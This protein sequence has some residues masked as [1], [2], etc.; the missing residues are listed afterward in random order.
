M[1][2]LKAPLSMCI[3][4]NVPTVYIQFTVADIK[5][6]MMVTGTDYL[7][8]KTFLHGFLHGYFYILKLN[9]LLAPF[10]GHHFVEMLPQAGISNEP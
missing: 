10:T 4:K 2:L 3:S 1:H 8:I 5:T 6:K 7:L 9:V